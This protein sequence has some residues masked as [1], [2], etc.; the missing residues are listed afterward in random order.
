MKTDKSLMENFLDEFLND[1][2]YE[3]IFELLDID[4]YEVLELAFDE[5]LIDE[6][7][8]DRLL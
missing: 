7:L 5:G 1:N 6:D 3:E 8:V 4:I 2:S